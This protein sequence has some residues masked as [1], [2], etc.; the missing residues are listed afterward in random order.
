[1]DNLIHSQV[2]NWQKTNVI[3]QKSMCFNGK[4]HTKLERKKDLI[5]I[6]IIRQFFYSIR[7][8]DYTHVFDTQQ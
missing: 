4:N 7:Y 3:S 2:P 8:K 6:P 1:M 5:Y